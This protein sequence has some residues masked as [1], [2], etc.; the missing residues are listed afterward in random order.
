MQLVWQNTLTS[1]VHVSICQESTPA[2]FLQQ[3]LGPVAKLST[4]TN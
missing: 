3:L 2:I 1:L 4:D